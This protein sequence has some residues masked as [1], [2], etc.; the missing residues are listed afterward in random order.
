MIYLHCVTFIL[1]F[2]VIVTPTEAQQLTAA[3]RVNDDFIQTVRLYPHVIAPNREMQPAAMPLSGDYTLQLEFDHLFSEYE[4]YLV[5]FIH[6]NADWS[7]SRLFPLDYLEG[8]NE[9]SIDQYE[10]SFNTR[11]PYI[12]YSF[13]L[14]HFKISGNYLLV[15]FKDSDT[16]ENEILS[17]QFVVF[18]NRIVINAS[19]D[20]TGMGRLTRMTQEIQFDVNYRGTELVDPFRNVSATIRQNQRWDN[21]I[22]GLSPT[23][24]RFDTRLI[25]FRHFASEN[26]FNGG[27][28]FRFFDLRSL[29]YFGM[30]VETVDLTKDPPEAIIEK[31][32]TRNGRAYGNYRD[33][34]GAYEVSHPHEGDY[35]HV[36]FFLVSQRLN[37]EVYLAGAFSN[38]QRKNA[39]KLTYITE[40]GGY[41]GSIFL[42]EGEYDYQYLVESE[43]ADENEFEGNH[44]QTE[45]EY[46]ILLYYYS[47]ELNTDLLI[48]YFQIK[49]NDF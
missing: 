14:P 46:E 4:R 3:T 45:N 42:K 6:C 44:F 9:F 23:N 18:D 17:Y 2:V 27:N 1:A 8:Y 24:V 34:N 21:S 25:E 28:Q 35:A 49:E 15:V 26:Q 47:R 38:W 13:Q 16:E 12:H 36:S 39:Y 19:A 30:N 43:T 41:F 11:V 29:R 20:V 33:R 40:N 7:K 32:R 37:G 5:K 10:F 48:G 22:Q 31:D